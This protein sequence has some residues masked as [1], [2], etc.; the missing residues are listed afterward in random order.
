MS[1]SNKVRAAMSLKGRK[2]NEAAEYFG[3]SAQ[4]MRN[5]LSRGSFSA[6]DLIKFADFLGCELSFNDGKQ[7][8]T[9]DLSDIRDEEQTAQD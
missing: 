8:I 5:K 7:K 9:L 4:A 2:P 3:I 1:I 6:E